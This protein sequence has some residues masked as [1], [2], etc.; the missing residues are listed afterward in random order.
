MTF[1]VGPSRNFF[2]ADESAPFVLVTPC[3]LS[4]SAVSFRDSREETQEPDLCVK[5]DLGET[6]QWLARG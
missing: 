2:A 3:S 1:V 6:A 5:P 4:S